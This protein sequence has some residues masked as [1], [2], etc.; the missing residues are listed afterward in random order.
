M[1]PSAAE[2]D[3]AVATLVDPSLA[4]IV[5]MVLTRRDGAYE[6][7]AVDG[8]VRFRR[9]DPAAAPDGSAG[10]ARDW[11][12]TVDAVTG[13][14]PLGDRATDRFAGLDA[15]LAARFPERA[16]NAYPFA[17]EQVAQLFDHPHAPDLCVVHTAS[18]HWADQGGHIGEHGSLG[19]VQSRAPFLISG[20]GARS[21]GLVAGPVAQMVDIAP[22]VLALLGVDPSTLAGA[23][24][25]PIDA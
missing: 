5:E 15:E 3:L 6:A 7:H 20:P 18:H 25:R 23:D 12:F 4:S 14:D 11:S 19:A 13:R 21:D 8:S 10:P 22:T 16:A 2:L 9:H 17:F 1:S 24:G